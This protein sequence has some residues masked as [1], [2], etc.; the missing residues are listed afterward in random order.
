MSY[1]EMID[2]MLSRKIDPKA[3]IVHPTFMDNFLKEVES[4]GD[5]HLISHNKEVA[6]Y[7]YKGTVA[8]SIVTLSSTSKGLLPPRMTTSQKNAISSPAEGLTVY[9]LTLHKLYVYDGSTWQAAW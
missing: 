6:G 4:K 1:T 5:Y 9:D 8:S 2:D 3:L 7:F